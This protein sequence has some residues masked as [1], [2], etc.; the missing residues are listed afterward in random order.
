MDDG[1]T[2]TAPASLT[3]EVVD[4]SI[5]ENATVLTLIPKANGASL[6]WSEYTFVQ[7][8]DAVRNGIGVQKYGAIL[9]PA[10]A[11]ATKMTIKLGDNTYTSATA[12]A[13]TEAV[14]ATITFA[15]D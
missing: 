1:A 11:T 15:K 10:N 5:D 12:I 4:K 7:T 14:G 13:G 8:E 2:L 6:A 3:V 9:I